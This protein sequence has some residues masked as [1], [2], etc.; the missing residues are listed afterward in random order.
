MRNVGS[1]T[2]RWRTVVGYF[3][4][5]KRNTE[6]NNFLF[7]GSRKWCIRDRVDIGGGGVVLPLPLFQGFEDLRS[8]AC[9]LYTSPSPRD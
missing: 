9:L 5:D 3:I 6:I 2:D 8:D 1:N 7:V 4:K